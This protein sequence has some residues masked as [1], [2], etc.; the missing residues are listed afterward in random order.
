MDCHSLTKELATKVVDYQVHHCHG[1]IE[2]ICPSNSHI[3]KQPH[4]KVK[5][6]IFKKGKPLSLS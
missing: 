1:L 2:Q 6:W 3:Y 5:I 4:L